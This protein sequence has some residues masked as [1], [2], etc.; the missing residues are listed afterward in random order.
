[1]SDEPPDKW[2]L[3]TSIPFETLKSDA[4]EQCVYWLLD[5]MGAKDLEWRIGG[6][7]KGAADQGRD[8]EATFYVPHADGSIESQ[9][10]WIECKGRS[11]TLDPRAVKTAANNSLAV[12]SLDSLVIV[13]NTTFSNA[14]RDWVKEWQVSHPRPRIKLWDRSSLEGFI[15]RHPSVALRLFA[16]ALSTEGKLK[17]VESRFWNKLEYSQ[18][19]FLEEIWEKCESIH[20]ET[21]DLLALVFNEVAHGDIELRPW[22]ASSSIET[23][24]RIQLL[25]IGLSNLPYLLARANRAGESLEPISKGFAYLILSM[26]GKIPAQHLAELIIQFT[27][28]DSDRPVPE[29]IQEFCLMPILD[30]LTT[31]LLDVC[32]E[33]C[34]RLSPTREWRGALVESHTYWDRLNPS[35]KPASKRAEKVVTLE[36]T[37]ARCNVGFKLDAEKT[38]PLLATEI[39]L[40]TIDELMTVLER[41]VGVRV[42]QGNAR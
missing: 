28:G 16:Q 18:I 10:W 35:T 30:G 15:S 22:L 1:M 14:T 17:S 6:S 38:C 19:N 40:S 32:T 3:P 5:A 21:L 37:T 34:A 20:F 11:K 23:S 4:L 13:T 29:S 31:E 42:R 24:D 7:G 2:I 26:I 8:L 36:Q 39:N 41:V 12:S 9:R 33:D 27:K 25:G